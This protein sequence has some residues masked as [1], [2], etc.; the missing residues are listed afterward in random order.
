MLARKSSA[1]FEAL[2]QQCETLIT[3]TYKPSTPFNTESTQNDNIVHDGF[4]KFRRLTSFNLDSDCPEIF[5]IF[6]DPLTRPPQLQKFRFYHTAEPEPIPGDQTTRAEVI[7]YPQLDECSAWLTRM[8]TLRQFEVITLQSSF[9]EQHKECLTR[10]SKKLAKT[11]SM[12]VMQEQNALG[13]IPPYLFNEPTPVWSVV[14]DS[15]DPD[16]IRKERPYD[17]FGR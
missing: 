3:F 15:S 1:F 5:P 17:P 16:A 7:R 4:A 11:V 12:T 6:A 10:I 2:N 8:P 9:T 14:F 13:Y